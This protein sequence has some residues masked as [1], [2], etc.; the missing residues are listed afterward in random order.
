MDGPVTKRRFSRR[1]TR[2]AMYM[3]AA[4]ISALIL[5]LLGWRFY[6]GMRESS[7][8]ASHRSETEQA[9]RLAAS[10]AAFF[11][12]ISTRMADTAR[13]ANLIAIFR[14]GDKPPLEAEAERLQ[15]EFPSALKLRLLLPGGYELDNSTIPPLGYACLTL[16][17]SAES[18]RD[19][20]A[21][22][23]HLFGTDKQHLDMLR[24]ITDDGG[25]LLG[26]IHL[27]LDVGLLSEAMSALS[28]GEGYAELQQGGTAVPFVLGKS[29]DASNRVGTPLVTAVNGTRF[30]LA[31]WPPGVRDASG[32]SGLLLPAS[33][34]LIA[35]AGLAYSILRRRLAPKPEK[36]NEVL[37]YGAIEAIMRG[38]HP[39]MEK[40]IPHLPGKVRGQ[41]A[42]RDLSRGMEGEDITRIHL[43]DVAP[44]ATP[45]SPSEVMEGSPES[46]IPELTQSDTLD[47]FD[48]TSGEEITPTPQVKP[49]KRDNGA[50]LS[51]KIFRAYDIRG[52]VGKE[53]TVETVRLI[54]Q[55]IGSEAQARGETAIIVGRDGRNSGPELLAALIEGL[56]TSGCDV[57][58]I[59]MVPTPVLYFATHFLE[60]K[61]GVI[62]TGSHNPPEYN[63]LKIV[64]GG[65]TLSEESIQTIYERAVN[66]DLMTGA[67]K[68]KTMEI[69][70]DYIRRISE[71]IPVALGH[72]FKIV[73]DC[74]NG[75]TGNLAP[76]LYRALG[77]DVIELY[78]EIDGNFPNHHPDPSQPENLQELID[79]VRSEKADLGF[80]FDGDGD[81]LGVVD[82]QG[83]IIW[84]DRQMMLLAR[85]VLSRNAGAEIIYDVK[86]SR[87]LRDII[88]SSGGKALMWK[89]GHSLI[90][91]KMKETGAPLAGEM[92]G[93]I[94]FK[95]R[96][97][98]FDDALYTGARMLEVLMK[99]RISP[100]EVFASLPEGIATPELRV[101]LPEEEHDGF[102]EEMRDKIRFEGAEIISI[103]GLRVEFPDGWGLV[104]PSNTTPCLVLRFEADDE[105]ALER[106][107][108]EFRSLML[109]IK[110]DL[111]LT[112]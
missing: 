38:A 17:K 33:L 40:L 21:T 104:R 27:S 48:I 45:T 24:R 92:S 80:A 112:F 96:W 78:C 26:M 31:Y 106:I 66:Q 44:P 36:E 101:D 61:S 83:K 18:T 46:D 53:L 50:K 57:I 94:F 76:Q 25:A 81:R 65:E 86:C 88:V 91:G 3:G 7:L 95:E 9:V 19:P 56:C 20:I 51:K 1:A 54:G 10:T 60:P 43:S 14:R 99:A 29:G 105:T 32:I 93:H 107:Q 70:T 67:G 6:S 97:Y 2:N 90:K 15:S 42:A 69:N 72:S 59:G 12:Q 73:V 82:N 28:L 39:G 16:L 62:L 13:Q 108:A 103:D 71:D 84:P 23:V 109:S 35:V 100:A 34:I 22:D 47:V 37:Y 5:L 68:L 8:E 85:D 41:E 87:H 11:E 89:T 58:D 52:V 77:H 63:G 75:V 49:A 79:R 110:A 98:G 111:R 74:G 30:Y 55:A 64:L 4:A 102:M